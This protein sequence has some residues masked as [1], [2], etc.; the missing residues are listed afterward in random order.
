MIIKG[1]YAGTVM[2]S[3]QD[4]EELLEIKKKYELISDYVLQSRKVGAP[5]VISYP[6]VNIITGRELWDEYTKDPVNPI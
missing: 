5:V 4:Y 6:I 3:E 1:Y 2:I